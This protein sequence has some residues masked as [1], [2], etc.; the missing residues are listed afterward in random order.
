MSVQLHVQY[1]H[2]KARCEDDE[3][4]SQHLSD[5]GRNHSQRYVRAQSL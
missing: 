3:S 2:T 4:R 5:R 1:P